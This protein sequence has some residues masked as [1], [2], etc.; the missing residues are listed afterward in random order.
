MYNY[1]HNKYYTEPTAVVISGTPVKDASTA[2]ANNG[3]ITINA[4]GGTGTLRYLIDNGATYQTTNT[5]SSLSPGSYNIVV[6]DANGCTTTATA[7]ITE[8]QQL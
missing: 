8:Q 1:S 4:N 2:G 3:S 7:S 5:F 6:Q